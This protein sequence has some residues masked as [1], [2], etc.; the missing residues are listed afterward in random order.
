MATR[1]TPSQ[2]RTKAEREAKLQERA[3]RKQARRDAR[4]QMNLTGQA[5]LLDEGW[6]VQPPML[7]SVARTLGEI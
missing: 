1:S 2:R 6:D 5:H 4:R 7:G 3:L